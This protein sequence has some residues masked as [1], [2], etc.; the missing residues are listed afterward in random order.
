[1]TNTVTDVR[2]EAPARGRDMRW[3]GLVVISLAQLMV[4]LDATIV[5][6]ALP[7]AQKAVGLTDVSRQWTVTAY[8]LTFG[9][10]LLLGGRLGD[11]LGR[12]RS[13]MIG[14]TGF[15]LASV[16]GGAATTPAMLIGA[17]AAQGV[18][19]ALI[20]PNTLSLISATFTDAA[21]RA[22]AFGV[23]TAISMSGGATGLILGGALTDYV[24]WRWCFY[25]NIVF[26]VVVV[27]GGYLALPDP[28]RQSGTR[29][30]VPGAVLATGGMLAL[31]YGLGEGGARGWTSPVILASLA[32][33]VVLLGSFLVAQHRSAQPLLPLRVL[34][35]R[36]SGGAFL[37]MAV[38]AFCMLGMFL[39]M[40]YQLQSVMGYSPL[41]AGLAFL[42]YIVTA[43]GYSTKVASKLL[44]RVRPGVM[45][46]AGLGISALGLLYLTQ[47][48]PSSSYLTGVFP[49]LFL[50]GLGVGNVAVPVFQTAMSATEA[51]DAGIVS[52]V[53]STSQQLGGSIGTALLNTI[54]TSAAATYLAAHVGRTGATQAAGVH[55]LAVACACGAV[56]ALAG[57]V[58]AGT[59]ITVGPKK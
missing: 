32:A 51:R 10:L 55:G 27:V 53:V 49:A 48:T 40:T 2:A 24:D 41:K 8:A 38:S 13:L 4:W 39:G 1:M 25:I 29:L 26:A 56:V 23:F 11:V 52:A 42:A 14:I 20:A 58:A 16:V 15:A 44:L 31:I 57:A 33:A 18:F 12:K 28:P 47:L 50:F 43:A 54:S 46:A 21:E 17:R 7:S 5:A 9:G 30:D 6:V 45:I 35:N 19:A 37:A 22:K 34:A 36:N 59:L 3:W